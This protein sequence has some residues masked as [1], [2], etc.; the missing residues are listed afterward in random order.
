MRSRRRPKR[1]AD[2][3]GQRRAVRLASG[4]ARNPGDR[5]S[6]DSYAA[7]LDA[8]SGRELRHRI[9]RPIAAPSGFARQADDALSH[10]FSALDSEA[11]LSLER[12]GRSG[13]GQCAE[14]ASQA[15]MGVTPGSGGQRARRR[16]GALYRALGQRRRRRCWPRRWAATRPGF[17]AQLID[18]SKARASSACARTVIVPQRLGP[19]QPHRT[20]STTARDMARLAFARCCGTSRTTTTVFSVQSWPTVAA[21]SETHNRMLGALRRRRRPRDRLHQRPRASTCVMSAMRDNRR[22]QSAW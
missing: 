2:R 3:Q 11:R 15:K 13:V 20:G 8:T 14:R 12:D 6:G 17:Q 16:H 5:W 21:R 7:H 18:A 1:R 4:R 19:A 10:P 9:R 22:L